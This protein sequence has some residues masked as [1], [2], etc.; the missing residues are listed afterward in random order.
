MCHTPSPCAKDPMPTAG[1]IKS[2]EDFLANTTAKCHAELLALKT[3]FNAKAVCGSDEKTSLQETA[4][5]CK[6]E[7]DANTAC[8]RT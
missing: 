5:A 7:I 2:C 3:C 1:A 8:L 4:D 6:T